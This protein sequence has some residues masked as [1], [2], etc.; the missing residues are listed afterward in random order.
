MTEQNEVIGIIAGGGQFPLMVA[1]SIRKQ[2]HRIV[3]VA[4][5]EETDPELA[6]KVDE[7]VWIRLGQ[8]GHLIKTLKK[9]GAHKALMAGSISKRLMFKIKPDLIYLN[10]VTAT[11]F[12]DVAEDLNIP[13]IV[14][15]HAFHTTEF[16]KGNGFLK[17]IKSP[18]VD[19]FVCCSNF[20]RERLISCVGVDPM[21]TSTIY[22][23]VDVDK[24]EKGRKESTV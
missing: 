5:R 17:K 12:I 21:K 10:S 24:V 13:L 20:I 8:L 19:H 6:K 11:E 9:N 15:V 2:G 23:G 14:H 7:I 16:A 3:A 4:H 1:D 18:P 22:Y